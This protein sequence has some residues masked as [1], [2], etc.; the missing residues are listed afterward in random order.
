MNFQAH[1]F[2]KIDNDIRL[3]TSVAKEEHGAYINR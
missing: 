2:E 3:D 1:Q